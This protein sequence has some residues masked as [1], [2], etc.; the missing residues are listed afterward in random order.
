MIS[1]AIP[2]SPMSP[3]PSVIRKKRLLNNI[4]SF[5]KSWHSSHGFAAK[6]YCIVPYTY[7][8]PLPFLK[9]SLLFSVSKLNML[10]SSRNESSHEIKLQLY[11]LFCIFSYI[12]HRHMTMQ[13]K[14]INQLRLTGSSSQRLGDLVREAISG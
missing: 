13:Y 4:L 3:A 5:C 7:E 2:P 1:S 9:L 6:G 10:E 11:V 14:K 12:D 8:K